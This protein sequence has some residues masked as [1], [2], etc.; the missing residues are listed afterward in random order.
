M[1]DS[2]R[3]LVVIDRMGAT[4]HLDG[5]MRKT[6]WYKIILRYMYEYVKF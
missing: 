4:M 5:V 2:G 3:L 6:H 1:I